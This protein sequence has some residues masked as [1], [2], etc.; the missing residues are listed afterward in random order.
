MLGR[1]QLR[2][3][4]SVVALL[5]MVV[6]VAAWVLFAGGP[7]WLD[8]S[9]AA[10]QA[11]LPEP[12]GY[13]QLVS[14]EPFP[15][16]DGEMCAWAPASTATTLSGVLQQKRLASPAAPASPADARTS[17]EIDRAPTRVI[18]DTYPTYSAI[19]VDTNSNEVYLQDENLFG[20]KVFD[21]LDNTPPTAEFTEPKRMVGGNK[22][23]LEF[24]CALYIDPKTGD[25]YSVAND[26]VDTLV[27]FPRDARG[28]VA[29]K[30]ELRT[31][32][33]TYGIAVD[34]DAQ[35]LFLTVEHINAV[36]VYRKM[37]AGEEEPIRTLQGDRTELE[38][39][40]GIAVDTKNNL[41]FVSNH[42]NVRDLKPPR[43]GRFEPPSIS[44]YPLQASGDTPPIRVIEGPK[45]QLNWPA[46]LFVDPERGE[47]FVANDAGDS[48]VVFRATDSGDVAPIRV[49]KGPQA[50]LRNPTGLFVDLKNDELWVSS[51]GNHSATVYP[52]TANGDVAPLRTIRS[53]PP[54][55]V[56]L[57]IGNPGAA[58]YDSKRDEILVPN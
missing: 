25:V 49:I 37:A 4:N 29:P 46:H 38:D 47:L 35:E 13:P 55:K 43:P 19:A 48:I 23:K 21:R 9:A 17:A 8:S 24:N 34:E 16:M 7:K 2:S 30:R 11:A 18:R 22:T 52:R 54:G 53:A 28:N 33:G 6:T 1:F 42:G 32:H 51:M 15:A 39:P 31:P 58:E 10:S 27:I 40:H 45:T 56:A 12:T 3:R 50:G 41:M 5:G 26:I 44:V 20:Y 57:A 36:V 14:I